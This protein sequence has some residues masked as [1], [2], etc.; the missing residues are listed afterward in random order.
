MYFEW[1]FNNL[2][3][4]ITDH[5]ERENT[6][7]EVESVFEDPNLI[8]K[9]GRRNVEEQRFN[10]VGIGN[11]QKVK[12]VVFTINN[13]LIRPISCWSANRQTT[14]YYYENIQGK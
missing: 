6:V 3:H 1:D 12:H 13:G 7:D 14:R 8:I 5:P 4:I 11:S 2:Q 10:A 9:V